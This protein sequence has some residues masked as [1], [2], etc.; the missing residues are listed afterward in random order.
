MAVTPAEPSL[1]HALPVG[2][3][4]CRKITGRRSWSMSLRSHFSLSPWAY[5]PS[6]SPPCSAPISTST[7]R[8]LLAACPALERLQLLLAAHR[9]DR[10]LAR[11][12]VG[13]DHLQLAVALE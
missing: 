10:D 6:S 3:P 8:E 11:A 9:H 12:V 5:P 2:A 1:R 13:Q 4:A 7:D